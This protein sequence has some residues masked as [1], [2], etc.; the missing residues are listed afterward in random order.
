MS[1]AVVYCDGACEPVNPG[2][3]ATYGWVAYWKGEE[4]ATDC[5]EVCRGDGATN[6]VA[7]YSA[8]IKALEF[9]IGKNFTGPL[10]VRSDSQLMINQMTG[11][12]GVKS[13]N[14]RPYFLRGR[15]L[16]SKFNTIIFEWVPRKKNERADWLSKKAYLDAERKGGRY[17]GN[18]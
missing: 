6:N 17:D 2:G 8:L 18:R 15:E 12:W 11:A 7:E 14:I 1:D 13:E 9:F 10:T 4:R 16:A 5:G 3:I